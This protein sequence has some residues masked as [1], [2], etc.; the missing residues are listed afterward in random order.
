[1]PKYDKIEE[2]L[3]ELYQTWKLLDA[4]DYMEQLVMAVNIFDEEEGPE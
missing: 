1:M 4:W 2:L 3:G